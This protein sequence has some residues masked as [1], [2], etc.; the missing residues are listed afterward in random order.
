MQAS[1][2]GATAPLGKDEPNLVF[3]VS[4]DRDVMKREAEILQQVHDG[5]N[6]AGCIRLT[7]ADDAGL[8]LT[9]KAQMR[10]GRNRVVTQRHAMQLL[11]I[12]SGLHADGIA[13]GDVRSKN[14]MIHRD[15]VLLIDFANAAASLTKPSLADG[16]QARSRWHAMRSWPPT[17]QV[18]HVSPA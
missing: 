13:H 6:R 8:V 2:P 16:S 3:K 14:V 12:L 9:P 15:D 18:S 17:H 7:F 1:Y 10:F 5:G 11:N 4:R